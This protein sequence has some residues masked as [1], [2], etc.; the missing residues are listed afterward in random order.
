MRRVGQASWPVVFAASVT[1]ESVFPTMRSRNARFLAA[2]SSRSTRLR[3]L[4]TG[5]GTCAASSAAAVPGRS[6]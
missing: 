1:A 2:A 4:R 6:E 5:I 3:S